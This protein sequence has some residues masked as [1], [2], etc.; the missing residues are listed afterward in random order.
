MTERGETGVL[1]LSA[2][3]L[4]D[5]AE[6]LQTAA[7]ALAARDSDR[8]SEMNGVG[9]NKSDGWFGHALATMPID[10]WSVDVTVHAYRTL[11]KYA[12]QLAAYGVEFS[13][14]PEPDVEWTP[15]HRTKARDD[16][17]NRSARPGPAVDTTVRVEFADPG[18][19]T[20]GVT[21]SFPYD[22][23]NVA[24]VKAIGGGRFERD[25]KAW[26]FEGPLGS[27]QRAG[28]AVFIEQTGA[29]SN[30]DVADLV[31]ADEAEAAREEAAKPAK[32]IELIDGDTR[33]VRVVFPY[34]PAVVHAVKQLP[35]AKFSEKDGAKFWRVPVS[36]SEGLVA[37][38]REHGFTAASEVHA[39]LGSAT[40]IRAARREASRA[41]TADLDL[42][43]FG[44]EPFPFQKA[45][46]VYALD[47]RRT[48]I[49]DDMGLG[50]TT[51]A[52]GAMYA[53]GAFPALV[54]CP[55]NVLRKWVREI[56]RAM[57]DATVSILDPT[58]KRPVRFRGYDLQ[59]RDCPVNDL[60][61]DVIVV[62]Y[63][64]LPRW[65]EPAVDEDGEVVKNRNRTVYASV[66][67]KP[68]AQLIARGDLRCLVLDESQYVKSR[69][70][71]RTIALQL[72]ADDVDPEYRFGLSG[73]PILNR[74]VELVEQ[75]SILGLVEALGGRSYVVRRYCGGHMGAHGYDASGATNLVEL[76]NRLREIGYIR[77]LKRDVL[78]E[79]P[80]KLRDTVELTIDN[81]D[82]YKR[83]EAETIAWLREQEFDK[84]FLAAL[85]DGVDLTDDEELRRIALHADAKATAA[86]NAEVLVRMN[87]LRQ[88]AA[89]GMM[90]ATVEWA[91]EFLDGG[92][93]KLV[94]WAFH[95]DIQAGLAD[96]LA[97]YGVTRVAAG[98]GKDDAVHRFQTD[99]S[100][101]VAVCSISA[102]REG[103]ELTKSSTAAFVELEWR[104][105]VHD[106]AED[107]CY[108]RLDDP[109]G[110]IAY[111]LVAED[112]IYG[113]MAELI[114]A[115]RKV[116]DAVHDGEEGTSGE[117][118]LGALVGRLVNSQEG[119]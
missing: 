104:P 118:I 41:T 14:I 82:E 74:P 80:A 81:R 79:L 115:K 117:S 63:D 52:L 5:T 62:N 69:T 40:E 75:L 89:R 66:A 27:K 60:D 108:G 113:D 10:E 45:G 109:H 34:D 12:K 54:V 96:A 101:R 53:A 88:L 78:P 99:E 110:L 3:S 56:W 91:R 1:T 83:A 33:H 92:D 38:A 20:V 50:K 55:D 59:L 102:G 7:Q 47:M 93:E 18:D 49:A 16:A 107:R 44:V 77:R 23:D 112:T 58:R 43:G 2:A 70:A 85:D 64:K 95:R 71:K 116:T 51:Q 17:W 24:R 65:I 35:G 73:T 46:I 105:G 6:Q 76:H 13:E 61:A 25:T 87:A 94:L 114:D 29:D 9:F 30:V 98:K 32:R 26:A 22:P 11:R 100:C 72:L 42:D 31:T 48:F 84:A 57:P 8:A 86:R 90:A 21:V 106:Q 15:G 4:T 36:A 97:E 19:P 103:V 37:V 39:A 111:Y 28:L 67:G 119:T 68:L